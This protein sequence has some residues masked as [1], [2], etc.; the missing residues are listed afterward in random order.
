ML[1]KQIRQ[2][3][4]PDKLI[5]LLSSCFNG[6]VKICT[7]YHIQID[8]N[9]GPHDIYI[10]K[11]YQ[12]KCKF[13]GEITPQTLKL[14]QIIKKIQSY[15]Y[16]KSQL[17]HMK[18]SLDFAI[19]IKQSEK[20]A[21]TTGPAIFTDAGFKDGKARIAAIYIDGSD[22]KA[23]SKLIPCINSSTAEESAILLGCSM[24]P[25]ATVYNDCLSTVS[26]YN[27]PR[28]KWLPRTQNKAADKIS[29][30]RHHPQTVLEHKLP[31]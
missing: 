22:I 15:P 30:L 9:K 13:A 14:D 20:D 29:N 25:F 18:E 31:E 10:N 16:H 27:V 3:M 21:N 6:R 12:L 28:V 8:S 17:D 7:Q 4:K 26:S 1:S 19:F 24:D 2:P 5:T 23:I 11:N